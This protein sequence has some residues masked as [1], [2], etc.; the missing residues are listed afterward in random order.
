MGCSCQAR[1]RGP[2]R[3]CSAFAVNNYK[4]SVSNVSKQRMKAALES[5]WLEPCVRA[6][7]CACVRACVR[8]RVQL[9]GKRACVLFG[10]TT[11]L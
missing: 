9:V 8:A 5:K 11:Y 10:V 7:V 6:C 2:L 4:F 1:S 3:C